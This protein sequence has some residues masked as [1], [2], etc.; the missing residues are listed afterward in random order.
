MFP[1]FRHRLLRLSLFLSFAA[2][3]ASLA[4]CSGMERQTTPDNK[5][6]FAAG[7]AEHARPLLF[8]GMGRDPA[9]TVWQVPNILPRG[10][11]RVIVRKSGPVGDTAELVDGYRFEVDSPEKDIYLNILANYPSPEALDEKYI[12]GLD[13]GPKK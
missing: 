12:V 11:Y 8:H 5:V 3:T 13:G 7:W 10:A 1:T 6:Q 9:Y 2:L 4:A